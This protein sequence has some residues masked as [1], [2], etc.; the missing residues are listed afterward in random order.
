MTEH[1]KHDLTQKVQQQF[2]SHAQNYVNSTIHSSS[3]SLDRLL[4]LA[5]I[6]PGQRAL[7]VATGGGHVALGM[8]KRG[9]DVI[10]SDLT[11]KMLN[12]ARTF[13]HEQLQ[14]QTIAG[15]VSYAQIEAGALPFAA[16]SLD[17]VTCRIAPHHFPSV[18]GFVR[19]AAR[20]IKPGGLV[21]MVDQIA[22]A[23]NR[24]AA[25][26]LNAF[27]RLRDPSH[28]WE[29]DQPDWESFFD[30]AGLRI[31]HVEVCRNRLEFGWWVRMQQCPPEVVTRL[32]VM[33]R[34][35]PEAVAEWLQPELTEPGAPGAMYFSLWQLIII[36]VKR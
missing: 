21:A 9:A 22:P 31:S 19:E 16:G 7:D 11:P 23:T 30:L 1:E 34:Q 4:E 20:V 15:P 36:G 24:A 25:E 27:E 14:T 6:E 33:L 18:E 3:Y 29:H 8:A 32:E 10:A 13:I 12:A 26:Y 2:G 5:S 35:A 28:Q 17:R